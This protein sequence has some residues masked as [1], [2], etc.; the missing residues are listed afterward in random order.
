[1][2]VAD[3]P[4]IN[5]QNSIRGNGRFRQISLDILDDF[6]QYKGEL[7]RRHIVVINDF[8]HWVVSQLSL[9]AITEDALNIVNKG[10]NYLSDI[11]EKEPANNFCSLIINVH[12]KLWKGALIP[13]NNELLFCKIRV[14]LS[15]FR[16]EI[17]KYIERSIKLFYYLSTFT[18]EK[19]RIK[20]LIAKRKNVP[21]MTDF[22]GLP[23]V[24]NKFIDRGVVC[25]LGN[26]I[27]ISDNLSIDDKLSEPFQTL[28]KLIKYIDVIAENEGAVGTLSNY[29]VIVDALNVC[30]KLMGVIQHNIRQEISNDFH[31]RQM[32]KLDTQY[33]ILN[34]IVNNIRCNI[35]RINI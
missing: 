21:S 34:E 18:N 6:S 13:I 1:M 5:Y 26:D 23:N 22:L 3:K 20:S 35:V 12:Y 15:R 17:K 2:N 19:I 32:Y 27:M 29:E 28:Y 25:D 10:I 4:D 31:L 11:I 14:E 16:Y 33:D 9:L 8:K 7:S 30:I 24:L